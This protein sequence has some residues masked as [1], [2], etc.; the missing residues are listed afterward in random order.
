[1][2]VLSAFLLFLT[3]SLFVT[4]VCG[5]LMSWGMARGILRLW[6]P[7]TGPRRHP[8]LKYIVGVE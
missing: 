3:K 8:G 6:G 4:R 2:Y 7:R 5:L 1:M